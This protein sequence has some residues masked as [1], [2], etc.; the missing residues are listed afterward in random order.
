MDLV[1][2]IAAKIDEVTDVIVLE[3]VF[4]MGGV[5]AKGE[6]IITAAL[7]RIAGP[8]DIIGALVKRRIKGGGLAGHANLGGRI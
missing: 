5:D 1:V 2:F 6:G 4:G 3:D 7:I 8:E